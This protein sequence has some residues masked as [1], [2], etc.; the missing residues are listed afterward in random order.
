MDYLPTF[1]FGLYQNS[2]EHARIVGAD[3]LDTEFNKSY[4]LY[5]GPIEPQAMGGLMNT[6]RYKEW[7]LS[8]FITMQ[9]GN[10][11]RINPTFDPLYADL[12]IFSRDYRDRWLSPGDEYHTEVPVLPSQSLIGAIG[13]ENIERAYN[14]YNFSQNKVADGS[15]IRLKSISLS[16]TAQKE[17]LE[18]IRLKGLSVRLNATNPLML[19]ADKKL[20]GQDPEYYRT[21]GVSLPTPKQVTVSMSITF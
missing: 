12:N 19:Y 15:F 20:N 9:A 2:Q 17:L 1:D 8:L 11:I 13:R 4:L 6:F 5:H 16:Y 10:K 3:F 7:E 18:R 14:T 21:G